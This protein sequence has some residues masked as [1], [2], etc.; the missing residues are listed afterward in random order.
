M[1]VVRFVVVV[2]VV[3]SRGG[4][5]PSLLK[6]LL[7]LLLSLATRHWQ[8][9]T[10][11]GWVLWMMFCLWLFLSS[12]TRL[13]WTTIVPGGVLWML[14]CFEKMSIECI[15]LSISKW[16]VCLNYHHVCNVSCCYFLCSFKQHSSPCSKV[17]RGVMV[18]VTVMTVVISGMETS[19]AM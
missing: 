19:G 12:T 3:I 5:F 13:W 8:T 9:T 2:V 11:P 1:N 10:A 7:W 6:L 17:W 15:Y 14:F 16:I 4:A 18:A